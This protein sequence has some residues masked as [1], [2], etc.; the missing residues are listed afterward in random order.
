MT[1][2]EIRKSNGFFLKPELRKSIRNMTNSEIRK[3]IGKFST[4]E[5]RNLL[6]I[7]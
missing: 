2:S 7:F 6:E 1:N 5:K 4:P 3:F